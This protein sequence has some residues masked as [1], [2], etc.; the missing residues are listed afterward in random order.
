MNLIKWKR[1]G[2][3]VAKS[4]SIQFGQVLEC[5]VCRALIV[6]DEGDAAL[7]HHQWHEAT[8]TLIIPET[9]EG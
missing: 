5:G 3:L 9:E 2:H 7:G 8:N 4:G 1:R 6:A